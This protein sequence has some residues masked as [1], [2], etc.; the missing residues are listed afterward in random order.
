MSLDELGDTAYL[1]A[2][3]THMPDSPSLHGARK[4]HQTKPNR[5]A[6]PRMAPE[7]LC[8]N[9]SGNVVWRFRHPGYFK[10]IAKLYLLYFSM[11]YISVFGTVLGK[12]KTSWG[13][14]KEML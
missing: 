12:K 8:P 10:S 13:T 14:C 7:T 1:Y 9:S 2:H 5:P 3:I 4:K 11:S 6:G